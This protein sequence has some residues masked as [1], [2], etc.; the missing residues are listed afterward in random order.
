MYI[1]VANRSHGGEGCSACTTEKSASRSSEHDKK[2]K[3]EA[4]LS[5]MPS[6]RSLREYSANTMQWSV[7]TLSMM[8]IS[9]NINMVNLT[10]DARGYFWLQLPRKMAERKKRTK[11]E[12]RMHLASLSLLRLQY[13]SCRIVCQGYSTNITGGCLFI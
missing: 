2:L 11:K 10:I 6:F 5:Y 9:N 1:K 13:K 7:D 12:R 3:R 4:I 8:L